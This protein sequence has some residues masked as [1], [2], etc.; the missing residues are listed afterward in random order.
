MRTALRILYL[1]LLLFYPI[2]LVISCMYWLWD[3]ATEMADATIA[4]RD[5]TIAKR[6]KKK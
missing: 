5:D 3:N 4:K 1:I 6:R 2:L